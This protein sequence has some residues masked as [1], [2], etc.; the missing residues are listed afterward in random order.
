MGKKSDRQCGLGQREPKIRAEGAQVA[1]SRDLGTPR[2]D[3]GKN[4][5]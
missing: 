4:G 5:E 3:R 1:S 2:H